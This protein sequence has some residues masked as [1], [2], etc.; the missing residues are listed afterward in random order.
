LKLCKSINGMALMFASVTE[1]GKQPGLSRKLAS[2]YHVRL[3][4]P[5]NG[6]VRSCRN[7]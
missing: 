1:H 4:E 3:Q 6:F 7:F 5:A 2:V